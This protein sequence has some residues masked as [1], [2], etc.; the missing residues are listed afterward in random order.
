LQL[1]SESEA[2]RASR[3]DNSAAMKVIRAPAACARVCVMAIVAAGL[4]QLGVG[5]G[6]GLRGIVCV[7]GG[8]GGAGMTHQPISKVL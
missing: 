7:C 8:G 1:K 2:L 6:G 3:N 5:W 4:Q